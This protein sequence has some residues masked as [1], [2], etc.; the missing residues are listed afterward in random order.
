MH[1]AEYR[2]GRLAVAGNRVGAADRVCRVDRIAV[3]VEA[4][5]RVALVVQLDVA[6]VQQGPRRQAVAVADFVL[7]R[8]GVRT[9]DQT[10]DGRSIRRAAAA[11]V[12]AAIEQ[13]DLAAAHG[14]RARNAPE[15][16]LQGA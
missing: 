12:G 6:G 4:V 15:G 3:D 2:A 9:F 14:N 11:V 8:P 5:L 13:V 1:D 16:A 7:L 10:A